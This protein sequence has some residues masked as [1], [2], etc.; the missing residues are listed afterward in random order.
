MYNIVGNKDV[1]TYYEKM[2]NYLCTG[3]MYEQQDD[4]SNCEFARTMEYND[5]KFFVARIEHV[6]NFDVIEA[7]FYNFCFLNGDL[8]AVSPRNGS[9][10]MSVKFADVSYDVVKPFFDYV[11][12]FRFKAR[13]KEARNVWTS[14]P[15]RDFAEWAKEEEL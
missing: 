15:I 5:H 13:P 10:Y 11:D 9:I 1:S 14:L 6:E 3:C 2:H 8:I 12:L 4:C 7:R